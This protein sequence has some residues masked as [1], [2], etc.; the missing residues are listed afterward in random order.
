MGHAI[1]SVID[2]RYRLVRVVST[3]PEGERYETRHAHTERILTILVLAQDARRHADLGQRLLDEGRRLAI[4]QHPFVVEAVDAGVD[5]THGPYLVTPALAG[6]TLDSV[7]AARGWL[8]VQTAAEIAQSL[9]AGLGHAHAKGI[10]HG[11]LTPASVLLPG[12][13]ADRWALAP[14]ICVRPA[15]LLDMGRAPRSGHLAPRGFIR[16]AD[17]AAPD[18]QPSD[19]AEPA[20]DVYAV[21]AILYECLTG[22]APGPGN[23]SNIVQPHARRP[24]VPE[25]MSAAVMTALLPRAERHVDMARLARALREATPQATPPAPR[26]EERRRFARAAYLA[27]VRILCQGERT[28][29]GQCQD[30]SEGGMLFV[31]E[32]GAAPGE[33]VRVR[34]ALPFS[35]KIITARAI[36][37]WQRSS[38]DVRGAVGLEFVLLPEEAA[39]D[40]RAYA[41]HFAVPEGEDKDP[42]T[43][44]AP[45][46]AQQG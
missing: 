30:I 28:C 44:V 2:R 20:D 35:G 17:Y 10:A 34:F 19:R 23:A 32:I 7:L 42:E 46:G 31:G 15:V 45:G 33:E 26:V 9:C 24:E 6:R 37:R 3:G 38:T 21:G 4:A 29:D 40:I 11:A 1:G 8:P 12:P 36:M 39:F 43:V 14:G 25:P 16:E 5:D 22:I 41:K 18:A 27:P 13:V